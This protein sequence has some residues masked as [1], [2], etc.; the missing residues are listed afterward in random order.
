MAEKLGPP[1]V[2]AIVRAAGL[3]AAAAAGARLAARRRRAADD[4]ARNRGIPKVR[5]ERRGA[6]SSITAWPPRIRERRRREPRDWT[7]EK[8]RSVRDHRRRAA[9][10][11]RRFGDGPLYGVALP[12]RPKVGDGGGEARVRGVRRRIWFRQTPTTARSPQGSAPSGA[13][14]P[15]AARRRLKR[16]DGGRGDVLPVRDG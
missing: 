7:A 12:A 5:R 10:R 8:P 1:D 15:P 3:A 6:C 2:K 11:H 14:P 4:F 16:G 13:A 9:T